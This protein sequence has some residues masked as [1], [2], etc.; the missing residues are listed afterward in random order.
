MPDC[1]FSLNQLISGVRFWPFRE[2]QQA[3]LSG[4]LEKTDPQ[5]QFFSDNLRSNIVSKTVAE[6]V[7]KKAPSFF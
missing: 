2:A 6:G 4:S 1:G 7:Y 5:N 3:H